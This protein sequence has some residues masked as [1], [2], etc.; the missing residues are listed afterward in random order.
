[1]RL[2][3]LHHAAEQEVYGAWM[4]AELARH[5]YQVSPGTLYPRLH[6][7]QAQG[8][9]SSRVIVV[10][11]RRRRLYRI[12][13]AGRH[14]LAEGRRALRE[15]ASEVLESPSAAAAGNPPAPAAATAA[16][17]AGKARR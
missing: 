14:A 9:L 5:G 12:T 15:L 10:Q 16:R 4:S 2:H 8:L 17:R 11:G 3:I 13:H 6:A 1:M 7:M